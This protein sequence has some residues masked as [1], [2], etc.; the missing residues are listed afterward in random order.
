MKFD[1]LKYRYP[2][3]GTSWKAG[4][5]GLCV[6]ILVLHTDKNKPESEGKKTKATFLSDMY[7]A[8]AAVHAYLCR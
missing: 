1:F 6:H 7:E 3:T 4:K 8:P 2:G 5:I